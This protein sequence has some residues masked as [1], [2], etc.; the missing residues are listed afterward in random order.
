[1]AG[2]GGTG[3]TYQADLR[4]RGLNPPRPPSFGASRMEALQELWTGAGL[5]AVEA[6]E[7]TVRRTFAD[8]DD[9]WATR[10]MGASIGP[11]V[12]AMASGDAER[13]KARVRERLLPEGAG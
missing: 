2:G 3:E 1:M 12:A 10:L 9:F 13:L 5:D 6:R 8:F 11:I 7:I 4:A